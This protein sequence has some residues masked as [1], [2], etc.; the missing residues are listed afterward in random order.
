MTKTKA[1]SMKEELANLFREVMNFRSSVPF[2]GTPRTNRLWWSWNL[3]F[4]PS[5]SFHSIFLSNHEI[6][7]FSLTHFHQVPPPQ[8]PSYILSKKVNQPS[9][10]ISILELS[11][12][13][14]LSHY[15]F[16]ISTSQ[17]KLY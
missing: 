6:S 2:G 7:L 15:P 4:L 11:S 8:S 13:R 9:P 5:P 1:P 16:S 10:H 14:T 12:I 3:F 17:A